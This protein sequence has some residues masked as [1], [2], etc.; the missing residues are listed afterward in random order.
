MSRV[1][2]AVLAA[3][4]LL[5]SG[6]LAAVLL[7]GLLEGIRQFPDFASATAGVL[8]FVGSILL[9]GRVIVDVAREHAYRAV[10]G[11]VG[12]VAALLLLLSVATEQ[13]GEGMEFNTVALISLV[14]A[15]FLTGGVAFA[16]RTKRPREEDV[17][18]TSDL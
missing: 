14:L 11:V 17:V 12:V 10:L 2:T 15:G 3:L 9:V 13:H 4:G 8:L 18:S 1:M 6:G 5:V 16:R 7:V